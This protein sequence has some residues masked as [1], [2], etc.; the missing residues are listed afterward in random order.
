[1]SLQTVYRPIDDRRSTIDCLIAQMYLR[2]GLPLL[3]K[4]RDFTSIAA[5][6]PLKLVRVS[7]Q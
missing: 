5:S 6:P 2:D 7:Q 3:T 4:D 1:L